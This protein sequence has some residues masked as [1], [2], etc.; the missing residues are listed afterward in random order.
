VVSSAALQRTI[1]FLSLSL[2][3]PVPPSPVCWGCAQSC[4]KRR[5]K[6][7]VMSNPSADGDEKKVD[8]AVRV[9]RATQR[10][11]GRRMMVLVRSAWR[12]SAATQILPLLKG[13]P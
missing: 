10:R 7:S 3:N 4:V 5:A 2:V 12:F 9:A 6:L 8:E 1:R 13:I 11:R